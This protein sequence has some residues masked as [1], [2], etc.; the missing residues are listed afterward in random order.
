M[1]CNRNQEQRRTYADR[2]GIRRLAKEARAK[3]L[4]KIELASPIY[5]LPGVNASLDNVLKSFSVVIAESIS[6]QA[7]LQGEY[8]AT[9][10]RL[11]VLSTLHTTAWQFV[12]ETPYMPPQVA[13]AAPDEILIACPGGTITLGGEGRKFS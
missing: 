3:G 5:D 1:S 4:K 10:Y 11:K 13:P 2:S 8:P 7:I 9:W 12:N 6:S